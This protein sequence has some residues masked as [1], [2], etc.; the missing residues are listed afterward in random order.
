M[1]YKMSTC[2]SSDEWH[3]HQTGLEFIHISL[4]IAIFCFILFPKP[5]LKI[6]TANAIFWIYLGGN[7]YGLKNIFLSNKIVLF[8]MIECWNFQHLFEIEFRETSQNFNFLFSLFRP[9]LFSFFFI[10]CLI[11]LKF[12]WVSQNSFFK[13]I[14][15]VSAFYLEKQ[16]GFI[17]KKNIP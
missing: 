16:Q 14:L 8:F 1:W 4:Q 6:R 13:Q 11:E 7:W 15:K 12:F 3:W 17:P 9:L 10:C 5:S 2:I